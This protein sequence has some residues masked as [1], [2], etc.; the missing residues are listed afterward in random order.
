M[1]E[2]TKIQFPDLR[3]IGV[4]LF[5][6]FSACGS[7]NTTQTNQDLTNTTKTPFVEIYT[8]NPTLLKNYER[9]LSR[10]SHKQ[11][12]FN[13]RGIPTK[14]N[15]P[16]RDNIAPYTDI[17]TLKLTNFTNIN[18]LRIDTQQVIMEDLLVDKDKD[19]TFMLPRF[20]LADIRSITY[21]YKTIN[22]KQ[23]KH[24]KNDIEKFEGCFLIDSQA[25]IKDSKLVRRSEASNRFLKR[26]EFGLPDMDLVLY[27]ISNNDCKSNEIQNFISQFY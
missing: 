1:K 7:N 24:I 19:E 5:S 11:L 22:N 10:L 14:F 25:V 15:V 8:P 17:Q 16:I 18:E 9:F 20:S 12:I 2:N 26:Y 4:F 3:F 27:K 13:P 6:I 23:S 21:K